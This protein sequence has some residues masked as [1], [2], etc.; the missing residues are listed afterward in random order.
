MNTQ[1]ILKRLA[2]LLLVA[3]ICP[4]NAFATG[5]RIKQDLFTPNANPVYALDSPPY[6]TTELGGSGLAIE[7]TNSLL[8]TAKTSASINILPLPKMLKY[9]LFQEKALALVGSH[10]SFTAEE[11]KSLIFVPIL[12]LQKHYYIYQPKHPEGL[13]WKGDLNA[14]ANKTYGADPEEDIAPYQKAG[15]RIETGKLLALLEKLKLGQID[16]LAGSEPSINWFLDKNLSSDKAQFSK[17]EPA[18]GDETF[19]VIFNK[20][21]PQGEAIA[22]QF[23]EGLTALIANGQYKALLEK[24][25]GGADAAH[26]YTLPLQ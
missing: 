8:Q 19:F 21:H 15:I 25:L 12:R 5:P 13:P 16:F 24:N 10:L 6:I 9:Y 2:L 1:T 4:M 23:K 22:K 14:L 7:L 18:A 3:A 26:R 20:N 17:L 11:Q